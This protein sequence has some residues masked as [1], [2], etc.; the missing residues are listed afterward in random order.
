MP[1]LN[2]NDLSKLKVD[3][4]FQNYPV[5]IETGT[6]MGETIF[7][8]EPLFQQLHTIEIKEAFYLRASGLYGGNKIK[9]HLGDSSVELQY[10]CKSL[11]KPVLFFLDGHW[12]AG[13]TGRGCKDCPL[14][15]ELGHIIECLNQKCIIIVDDVRLFGMGPN[16]GNEICNWEDINL[17]KILK[18]VKD[19]LESH[20]F[21]DSTFAES[22]RLVL[23]LKCK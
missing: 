11:D 17:E 9:F 19:R 6:Y 21:I 15:E 13:N 3:R 7:T 5:F 16:K 2:I 18:I 12:S 8:M 23:H 4:L 20:Y 1:A 22:D 14:Y 10:V